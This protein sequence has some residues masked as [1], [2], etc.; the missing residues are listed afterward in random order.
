MSFPSLHVRVYTCELFQ[1]ACRSTIDKYG[2]GS[3]G[4]R[5]FYGTFDVH[6]EVEAA[7]TNFLGAEEC[8]LYS[9]AIACVSS[10]IPAFAK[11]GDTIV[12]DSSCSFAIQQGCLLSRSNI[13][14]F[15]HGDVADLERVLKE[16]ADKERKSGKS[17]GAPLHRKF[18][19]VEGVSTADGSVAPLPRMVA[20]KDQYKFRM[21]IDDS[22]GF[23]TMGPTGRGTLEHFGMDVKSVDALCAAMDGSLA[24]VGG[25]CVGSHQV[26]DHQRLS[27]AGYCFSASSPP[28]TS[29]ASI[30]ALECMDEDPSLGAALRAKATRA[31]RALA[32]AHKNLV[33][34]GSADSV[35][36]PVIHL[37]LKG[38]APLPKPNAADLALINEMQE[39]LIAQHS[40][41]CI[42][43][44]H[45][46]SDRSVR[47]ASL[48]IL[49]S[50]LHTDADIDKLVKA[51]TQVAQAVLG[52]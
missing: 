46:P 26:V 3:C 51:V 32:Q 5:G 48:R 18:L 39:R 23:G 19:V 52:R 24:S 12:V 1:A 42:V 20:L 27:G 44:E 50:V 29:T 47:N 38:S 33:V 35:S 28:Y 30:L 2:V 22:L 4:P 13:H 34:L 37:A 36:S 25:F 41:V 9:D 8:I 10:V 40:I 49:L 21:I 45:I 17:K 16:L 7:I 6:L 31:R 11:K 14:Y 43:P 15:K